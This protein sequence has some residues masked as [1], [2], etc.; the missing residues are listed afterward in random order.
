M[1][2][3]KEY[4]TI[5]GLIIVLLIIII[6]FI[7]I[8][9]NKNVYYTN[10]VRTYYIME[11]YET[12]DINY[13]ELVIKEVSDN[14]TLNVKVPRNVLG[15]EIILEEA[16]EFTFDYTGKK[17]NDNTEEIFKKM[18]LKNVSISDKNFYEYRQ[19]EL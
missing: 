6:I 9:S 16:Y 7:N 11:L 5:G 2:N 15:T 3:K 1:K 18:S 19:D 17:F 4:F 10:F 8:F 12:D 13:I 14:K